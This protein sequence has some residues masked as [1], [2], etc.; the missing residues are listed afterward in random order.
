MDR[1]I[2]E[3]PEILVIGGAAAALKYGATASALRVECRVRTWEPYPGPSTDAVG[4]IIGYC[5]GAGSRTC[6]A[7]DQKTKRRT[8][9]HGSLRG[10]TLSSRNGASRHRTTDRGIFDAPTEIER[11]SKSQRRHDRWATNWGC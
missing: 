10:L 4:N 2:E 11:S 5:G 6:P 1:V 8:D 7:N 3:P 9:L